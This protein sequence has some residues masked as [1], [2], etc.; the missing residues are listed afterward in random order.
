MSIICT[1]GLLDC[2]PG[3]CVLL[4]ISSPGRDSRLLLPW[5]LLPLGLIVVLVVGGTGLL[6][7]LLIN[8]RQVTLVFIIIIWHDAVHRRPE[9]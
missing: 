9:Y 7:H 6:C 2:V 1:N 3:S 8:L 5:L 4:V